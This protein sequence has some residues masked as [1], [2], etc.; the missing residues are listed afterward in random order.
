MSVRG[1]KGVAEATEGTVGLRETPP[2]PGHPGRGDGGIY[3]KGARATKRGGEEQE[4]LGHSRIGRPIG[5]C[6]R[7]AGQPPQLCWTGTKV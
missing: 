6:C 1:F 5:G 3:E 4:R 7:P 2:D